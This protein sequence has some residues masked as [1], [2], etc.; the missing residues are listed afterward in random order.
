MGGELQ[1]AIA[2]AF[3]HQTSEGQGRR[4]VI[5]APVAGW[6]TQDPEAGDGPF[7]R[8][9]VRELLSRAWAGRLS[10]AVRRHTLKPPPVAQLRPCLI[11][12]SGPSNKLFALTG[13]ALYD[14]TTPTS[15]TEETG[16]TVTEGRWRSATM[17]GQGILV[18]GTDEPLQDRQHRSM[19]GARLHR[20]WDCCQSNS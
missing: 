12:F 15:V 1:H 6:N 5:P 9:A 8:H 14:V 18:N 17:N 7:V 2:A 13:S 16:V 11:G 4:G 10:D 19:G 20:N 3:Q